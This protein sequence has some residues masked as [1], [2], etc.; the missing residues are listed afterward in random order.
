M[1]YQNE[2][3]AKLIAADSQIKSANL[4]QKNTPH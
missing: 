1:K 4:R 3:V 2:Q